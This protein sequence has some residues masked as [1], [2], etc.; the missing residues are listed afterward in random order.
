MLLK[1][2]LLFCLLPPEEGAGLQDGGGALAD[3]D[4]SHHEYSCC[5]HEEFLKSLKSHQQAEITTDESAC[6]K[7]AMDRKEDGQIRASRKR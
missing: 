3:S 2:G 4:L 1:A 6:P 7:C 5:G